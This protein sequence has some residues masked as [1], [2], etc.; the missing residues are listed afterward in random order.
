MTTFKERI[1]ALS[2]NEAIKKI[3]I[4]YSIITVAMMIV[5]YFIEL[6][7]I[8]SIVTI[9]AIVLYTIYGALYAIRSQEM[10]IV[11]NNKLVYIILSDDLVLFC[12][13]MFYICC[14]ILKIITDFVKYKIIVRTI[15]I[16]ILIV[17]AHKTSELISK[18][19]KS[20]LKN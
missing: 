20:K 7:P 11:K 17:V 4:V 2:R 13:I 14:P 8:I 12:Y 3:I 16:L 18:H 15:T 1:I 5:A 10:E 19:F 9:V 6:E